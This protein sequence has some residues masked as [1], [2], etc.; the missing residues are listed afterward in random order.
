MKTLTRY[1]IIL[2]HG[3]A[4]KDSSIIPIWGRIPEVLMKNNIDVFF[5]NTDSWASYIENSIQLAKAI[6][7]ALYQTQTEKVNIIAHSK[8]GIDSRYLASERGL[9][10]GSKIASLTTISTP[11]HGSELADRIISFKFINS[12]LVKNA[13]KTF[14]YIYGD[15]N[16]DP[17][18]LA[19]ELTTKE[20]KNFNEKYT[21][22]KKTFY[23][24]YGT[25][26]N[27]TLEDITFSVTFPYIKNISGENDGVVSTNSSKWGELF[28]LI[29]SPE[30]G[31]SH[32]EIIDIKCKDISG[33]NVPTIYLNIIRDLARMGY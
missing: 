1:P 28:T 16:P 3:I 27:N 14:A 17:Y 8:G 33:I 12:S 5:G 18:R 31:I 13:S 24:S 7:E 19:V 25:K 9:G 11:H 20:M 32:A 2:V 15:K 4:A 21:D 22:N 29:N 30:R 26:L 10:Y 23:Q 6:D